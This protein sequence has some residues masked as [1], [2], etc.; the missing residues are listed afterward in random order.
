MR[1]SPAI[2]AML[3]G[4]KGKTGLKGKRNKIS[5]FGLFEMFN[6][7]IIKDCQQASF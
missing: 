6:A 7:D 1:T 2:L 5:D 3:S 4:L